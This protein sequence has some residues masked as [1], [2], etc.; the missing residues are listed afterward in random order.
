[1]QNILSNSRVHIL[2]LR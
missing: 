2:Q 1:M